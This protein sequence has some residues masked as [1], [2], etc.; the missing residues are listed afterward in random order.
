[1]HAL[2]PTHWGGSGAVGGAPSTDGVTRHDGPLDY[3]TFARWIQ[4]MDVVADAFRQTS[5]RTLAMITRTTVALRLGVPVIHGCDSEVSDMIAEADAGWVVD[6]L[7]DGAWKQAFSEAADP[8]VLA[9]KQAGALRLSTT[10]FEPAAALSV[11]AERL[12][13]G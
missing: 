3:G 4:S 8:D 10:R 13:N 9:R 1:V 5:E 12:D 2:Q 6:P 7:D 11:A